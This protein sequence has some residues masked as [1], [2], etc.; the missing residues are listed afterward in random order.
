MTNNYQACVQNAQNQYNNCDGK[1]QACIN[2]YANS[3]NNCVNPSGQRTPCHNVASAN[4]DMCL[5]LYYP[6]NVGLCTNFF[7]K[8][9]ECANIKHT[10][11]N[12]P[13]PHIID[14]MNYGF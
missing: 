11:T 2:N 13:T 3:L 5:N 8:G 14:R 10:Q 7:N 12:Q 6:Q 9:L 4:L 1:K